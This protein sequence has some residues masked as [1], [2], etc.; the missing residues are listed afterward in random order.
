MPLLYLPE[1]DLQSLNTLAVPAKARCY[2]S[3]SS[4]DEVREALVF[5]KQQELPLLVLG[6]GSNIVLGDYFP[7]LALHIRLHGKVLVDDGEDFVLLRVAAGENWHELVEYT[8]QYHY[9]GLE[10]LSLIPGSVGAAPIQ[11]I[12]AYGVELC[13]V[14][15]ELTAI[16]IA[17]GLSVTF[18]KDACRFGYR[19]SV[20]KG[21][22]KDR[23]IITSVTLKL[24]KT[25]R[26][27]LD[28]PALREA[29]A[30]LPQES[31]TPPRVSEAV[32]AIRRNKLPHPQTLPNVGSFFKNPVVSRAHFERLRERW[33]AIV[34]F[35]VDDEHVKLAAAWLIDNAGWR[36]YQKDTVAVHEQQALVL[37]NPGRGSGIAVWNLAQEIRQSV[38]DRYGIDLEPEPR[39][40]I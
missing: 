9:W 40:Y 5:A 22:L 36:G 28:Y 10:N 31:L 15:A 29:L 35:P 27:I 32:C 39:I 30:H 25:S 11:N 38:A 18:D 23:Y 1:F 3:V 12:G 26:L 6:G 14:F 37:L 2:V 33:P 4:E 16:D 19:D 17:S 7:G 13:D 8:L 34:A 24:R 21:A 20:F